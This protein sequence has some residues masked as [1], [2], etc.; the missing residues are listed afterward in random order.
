MG[1]VFAG[2][3]ELIDM[4]GEGGMGA[5]WRVRDL[6]RDRIIAAKVL[7]QSDAGSLL[8]FMR[9]QGMRIHHPHVVTPLGWAGEDDKVLFTMPIV[10]GGS[11]STLV[12][13]YGPLPAP[14]AAELLRQML[15]ALAGVHD[16]GVVH[17][18]IKPANL[19]L[20]ATGTGRPHLW[21][22][23]FGVAVAVDA[24]RLTSLSVVMGTPGYLAPEQLRGADP[25][26]RSDLYAAGMVGFQMLTGHRPRPQMRSERLDLPPRPDATP[27]VLW[28]LLVRLAD[29]DRAGRPSSA[30]EALRALEVPEL[31]WVQ[32]QEVEVFRQ[33]PE[34]RG[35][36]EGEFLRPGED[37]DR[38]GVGAAPTM[39]PLGLRDGSTGTTHP[40]QHTDTRQQTA[41]GT[42][43]APA[44]GSAPSGGPGL[45]YGASYASSAPTVGSRP[46]GSPTGPGPHPRAAAGP[47]KRRGPLAVLVVAPVVAALVLALLVLAP[48]SS[49][50]EQKESPGGAVRGATC[51][52]HDAGTFEGDRDGNRLECAYRDGA[53]RWAT[54]AG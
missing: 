31:A 36:S 8:R 50:G 1:E 48:W 27:A 19:L 10:E 13:D 9:E 54:P 5:V 24:P 15:S 40:Q 39:R 22:T 11:V 26:P 46:Y 52:W 37:A 44:A 30:H 16:A 47:R 35:V 20:D 51:A 3:Y 17:R 7:R 43:P 41:G 12:G 21:L 28:D 34:L 4:I 25:D 29:P 23:D 32:Q 33:M 53:Y 2:R 42:R 18:D 49:S 38:T 45:A 14:Y 6:K